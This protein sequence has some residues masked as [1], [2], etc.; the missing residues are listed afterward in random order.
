MQVSGYV[1]LAH[2]S[3]VDVIPLTNLRVIRGHF[4]FQIPNDPTNVGYSLYVSSNLAKELQLTSLHGE[5]SP[6]F[7]DRLCVIDNCKKCTIIHS[8]SIKTYDV[9]PL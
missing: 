9:K 1:L 8:N 3:N 6:G 5:I 7:P 2:I 4:M